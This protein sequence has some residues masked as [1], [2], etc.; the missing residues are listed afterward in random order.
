MAEILSTVNSKSLFN[1]CMLSTRA[2][3]PPL[4]FVYAMV[5]AHFAKRELETLLFVPVYP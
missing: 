4:R 2:L 5:M 3:T 1:A